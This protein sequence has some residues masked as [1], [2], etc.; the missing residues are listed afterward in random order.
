MPHKDK[1]YDG[2]LVLE[3]RGDADSFC[4]TSGLERMYIPSP[5]LEILRL[6]DWGL[7]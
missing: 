2:H 3:F 7:V 4:V 6:R 5:H 1:N